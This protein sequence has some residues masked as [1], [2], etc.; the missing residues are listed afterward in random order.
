MTLK[1]TRWGV[2]MVCVWNICMTISWLE[3]AGYL[4]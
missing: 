4:R 3:Y 1:V 2:F